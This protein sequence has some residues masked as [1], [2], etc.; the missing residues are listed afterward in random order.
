METALPKSILLVEDNDT[1][2][3]LVERQLRKSAGSYSLCRATTLAEALKHLANV[4]VDAV[5]LDLSLPDSAIQETLQQVLDHHATVPVIVLTSLND[6]DFAN[7]AVKQGAQDFLVKGELSANLLERSIRYAIERK[8]S[9]RKLQQYAASLEASN[10]NLESF[11]H[12]LAHEV[13]SPLSV[14]S[15]C[16]QLIQADRSDSDDVETDQM[17]RDSLAAIRGISDLV[18]RLLNFAQATSANGDYRMIS[19]ECV[20]HEVLPVIQPTLDDVGGQLICGALP[21]VYADEVQLRHLLQNLLSNAIKYRRPGTALR[22]NVDCQTHETEWLLRV[23]DNGMGID[24]ENHDRIFAAFA[25][26][27]SDSDIAGVGI[28]LAFCKRIVDNHSGRI[29]VES[30]LGAGST[31]IVSLPKPPLDPHTN[32]DH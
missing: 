21:E 29:W 18:N 6:L 11:A 16:L 14:V 24:H 8:N 30:Q 13:R 20:L 2:A 31:F 27:Q 22:I 19:L 23:A 9:Q 12:T 25:R 10:R 4:D 17:I 7:Q 3:H 32:P 28:G 5:L 15:G 26:V 1:H